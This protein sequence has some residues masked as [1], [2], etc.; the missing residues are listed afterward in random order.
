M[1]RAEQ[2]DHRDAADAAAGLR[3]V[4][5]P[6]CG[7]TVDPAA[8]A[9]HV[10]VAGTTYHFCSANCRAKFVADP[11]HYVGSASPHEPE[12]A[13]G[14]VWTCPMHPEIRLDRQGN[15]PIC[16]T[17]LEPVMV[18]AE[19]EPS[20]ELADMTRRFWVGLVLAL[21]VLVL[22]MGGHIHVEVFMDDREPPDLIWWNGTVLGIDVAQPVFLVAAFYRTVI[23]P[24]IVQMS[25]RTWFLSANDEPFTTFIPKRAKNLGPQNLIV[26]PFEASL[27]HDEYLAD[28]REPETD[29]K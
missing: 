10:E 19:A 25:W 12:A 24:D 20:P 28:K 29:A 11:G 27:I 17:T 1:T 21:P 16:G 22:E 5:D 3:R 9:H 14:T 2:I 6:V 18:T 26:R 7:I 4:R 8:T 23:E 13:P 15:C